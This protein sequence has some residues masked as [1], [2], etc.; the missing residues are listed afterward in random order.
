MLKN[1][2]LLISNVT[3]KIKDR[4]QKHFYVSQ[5]NTKTVNLFIHNIFIK[6]MIVSFPRHIHSY[7]K[8]PHKSEN[9]LLII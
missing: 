5:K 1:V 7:I 4:K 9:Y 8:Y 6:V 3:Y 2:K